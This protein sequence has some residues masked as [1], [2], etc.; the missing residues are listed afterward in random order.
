MFDVQSTAAESS[1]QIHL[2]LVEQI[3]TLTLEPR[4]RLRLD[5]KHNISR[6]N[7]GHLI[8]LPSELDLVAILNTLVDVHMQHLA[9]DNRLLRIAALAAVTLTDHLTFTTA[10]IAHRL[11]AL[12]H[13][14]HLAHHGLHTGTIASRARLDRAFLTTTAVAARTDDRLLQRQFRH[15][16]AVDV[17][18]VNLVHVVDCPGLLGASIAHSTTEHPAESTAAEELRKQVLGAHAAAHTAGAL[19]TLLAI[20]VV[21]SAFLV[22]RQDLVRVGQ[23]LEFFGCFG[24]VG[25]LICL[26]C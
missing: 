8:T 2:G 13:G 18:Q 24:V 10:V 22:V 12:D 11:E 5:L 16:T 7:P 15:L 14:A 6:H 4:V 1:E 17:L 9:L 20:L 21:E 3:V 19:E 25:V 23:L 26:A